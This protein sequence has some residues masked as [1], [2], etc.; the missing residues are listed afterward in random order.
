MVRK[1][2]IIWAYNFDDSVNLFDYHFGIRQCRQ[3]VLTVVD[4]HGETVLLLNQIYCILDIW[5]ALVL[6]SCGWTGKLN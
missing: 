4:G 6:P 1:D 3:T 5:Y 2:L